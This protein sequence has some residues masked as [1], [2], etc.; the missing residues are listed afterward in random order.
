MRGQDGL[1]EPGERPVLEGAET[2]E[3]APM[4]IWP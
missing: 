4:W 2:V 3:G 1:P